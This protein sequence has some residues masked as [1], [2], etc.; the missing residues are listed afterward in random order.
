MS[1]HFL[2]QGTFLT[3]ELNPHLFRLL[4]WQVDP[5]PLAPHGR[6]TYSCEIVIFP[7]LGTQISAKQTILPLDQTQLITAF[8]IPRGKPEQREGRLF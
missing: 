3:Q 5:L 8:L 1:F 4:H 2:L 7:V 6:P